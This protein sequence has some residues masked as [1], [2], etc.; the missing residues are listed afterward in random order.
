MENDELP[1]YNITLETFCKVTAEIDTRHGAP[2][3]SLLCLSINT[4]TEETLV[5]VMSLQQMF[6]LY[7]LE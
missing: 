6:I 2:P 3:F 5:Q 7:D 1:A 4:I